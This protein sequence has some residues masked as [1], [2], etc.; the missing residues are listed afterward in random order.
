MRYSCPGKPHG[1]GPPQ[2]QVSGEHMISCTMTTGL[3][4]A[5]GRLQAEKVKE[6]QDVSTD[7]QHYAGAGVR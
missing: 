6:R 7:S 3:I 1:V 5:L 4:N 2:A